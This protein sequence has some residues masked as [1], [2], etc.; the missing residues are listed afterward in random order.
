MQAPGLTRCLFLSAD[1]RHRWMSG[2]LSGSSDPQPTITQYQD[3]GHSQT[4]RIE[5]KVG[6]NFPDP[7][8]HCVLPTPWTPKETMEFPAPH[9]WPV[10][11]LAAGLMSPGY[12]PLI[13]HKAELCTPSIPLSVR[14]TLGVGPTPLPEFTGIDLRPRKVWQPSKFNSHPLAS[15]ILH[16]KSALRPALDSL[17]GQTRA[18]CG[19]SINQTDSPIERKEAATR[20]CLSVF[21]PWLGLPHETVWFSQIKDSFEGI[22]VFVHNWTK[23]DLVDVFFTFEMI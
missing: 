10:T 18:F 13:A 3:R 16:W 17:H 2:R 12:P 6:S 20:K 22:L 14:P 23:W 8:A 9:I 1:H 21:F 7:V 19:R 5:P 15:Y 4:F 11:L